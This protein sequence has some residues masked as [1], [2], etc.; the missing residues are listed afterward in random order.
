MCWNFSNELKYLCTGY[1][2]TSPRV[3]LLFILLFRPKPSLF[4][5]TSKQPEQ[6]KWSILV[7]ASHI[8]WLSFL[9]LLSHSSSSSPVSWTW[10]ALELLGVIFF[11]LVQSMNSRQL[12]LMLVPVREGLNTC[13]K[14]TL[15][16]VTE[17]LVTY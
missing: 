14:N 6:Q 12:Q 10:R 17:V 3:F 9:S 11:L 8:P 1:F 16:P 4:S 13:L 2:P 15:A 7:V 5:S